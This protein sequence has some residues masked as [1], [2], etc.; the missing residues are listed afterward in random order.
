MVAQGNGR[1][2]DL[3]SYR[4]RR[5]EPFDIADPYVEEAMA[6]LREMRELGD[7]DPEFGS[8]MVSD[9]GGNATESGNVGSSWED[10]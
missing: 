7:D 3:V 4:L 10:W 5:A 1:V 8:L 6:A 9:H 2:I